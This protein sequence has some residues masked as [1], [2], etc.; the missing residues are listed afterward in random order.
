[1][2]PLVFETTEERAERE[3]TQRK[4][5]QEEEEKAMEDTDRGLIMQPQARGCLGLP[6]SVRGKEEFSPKPSG[7]STGQPP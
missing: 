6:E 2:L 1:M 3:G 4:H 7:E 5:T